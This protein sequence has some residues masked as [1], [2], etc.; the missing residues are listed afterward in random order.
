MPSPFFVENCSIAEPIENTTPFGFEI[1]LLTTDTL[2]N[3][4]RNTSEIFQF[5]RI[6]PWSDLDVDEIPVFSS[7]SARPVDLL[8]FCDVWAIPTGYGSLLR[9]RPV[10]M[11]SGGPFAEQKQGRVALCNLLRSEERRVGKECRSRW[12]PYH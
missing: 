6:K 10:F 11:R 4:A 3:E 8:L 7:S 2:Y 5:L 12:S 9:D 1:P